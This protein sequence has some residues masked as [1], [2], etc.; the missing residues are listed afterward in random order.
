MRAACVVDASG[1]SASRGADGPCAD[2]SAD[3]V[4]SPALAAAFRPVLCTACRTG[5]RIPHRAVRSVAQADVLDG[6][7]FLI[8]SRL[9]RED[10]PGL[11]AQDSPLAVA[12]DA[13]GCTEREAVVNRIFPDFPRSHRHIGVSI[14][15][16]GSQ[17]PATARTGPAT[18]R[19]VSRNAALSTKWRESSTIC[20]GALLR[21]FE[22]GGVQQS[23]PSSRPQVPGGYTLVGN[24]MYQQLSSAFT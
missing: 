22:R 3:V 1:L 17:R 24:P 8:G 16:I 23:S 20:D 14:Q 2:G 6:A 9:E 15:R 5:G 19:R 10:Q 12:L 13:L 21:T 18:S 7:G 11:L 4:A